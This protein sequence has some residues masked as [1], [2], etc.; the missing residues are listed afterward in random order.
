MFGFTLQ[1]HFHLIDQNLV[2]HADPEKVF[3]Y[4]FPVLIWPVKPTAIVPEYCR[5]NPDRK[6]CRWK[7]SGL[8]STISI[9]LCFRT[10]DKKQAY[11]PR[12]KT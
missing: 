8:N 2:V 1:D 5:F 12:F 11:D 9:Y 7:L 3:K 10:N 4:P 6:K